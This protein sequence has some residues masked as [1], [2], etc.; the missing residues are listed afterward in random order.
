MNDRAA[1]ALLVAVLAALGY[2]AFTHPSDTDIWLLETGPVL[3]GAVLLLATWRRFRLTTLLCVLLALHALLLIGGGHYTYAEVPFG[4]WM[5]EVGGFE[6]NPYD[7]LGHFAQG[8]VPAIL[9]CEI[10]LRTSPLQRG[11]WLFFLVTCVCLAFS[12]FYELIEWQVAVHTGDGSPEFLGTQGDPWDAQWDMTFALVGAILAQL[13][14]APLHDR[15]L[16]ALEP[17]A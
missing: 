6:R 14:L 2:S 10:L 13:T 17:A 1:L 12:A 16:A 11:K 3:I 15:Q 9:T 4:F 8:F 5:Q 7:R